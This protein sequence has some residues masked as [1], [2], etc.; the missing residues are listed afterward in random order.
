MT[1]G[2]KIIKLH[3]AGRLP[4]EFGKYVNDFD[5]LVIQGST[6]LFL[7]EETTTA[8]KNTL[9]HH[10]LRNKLDSDKGARI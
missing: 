5:V 7:A 3:Q 9:H 4:L 10:I 8:E 6:W 2:G 1:L